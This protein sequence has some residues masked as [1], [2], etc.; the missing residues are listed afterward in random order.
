MSERSLNLNLSTSSSGLRGSLTS[1][2]QARAGAD[3]HAQAQFEKALQAGEKSASEAQQPSSMAAVSS[4]LQQTATRSAPA[5][6]DLT[7]LRSTLASLFVDDGSH[8]KRQAGMQLAED[9]LPGVTV[10]VY[11]D[12]GAWIADFTCTHDDSRHL[13]YGEAPAMAQEMANACH[14]RTAWRVMTDD[15]DDLCLREFWADPTA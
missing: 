12:E 14:R 3:A 8:G 7:A 6:R 2:N 15:E 10:M 11:E 4:L 13:L 9:V 1:G 5:K